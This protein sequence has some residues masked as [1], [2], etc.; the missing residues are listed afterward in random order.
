MT[1][2]NDIFK[3]WRN[4]LN[5]DKKNA[6]EI[7][8]EK[9]V[10]GLKSRKY[11]NPGNLP[12]ETPQVTPEPEDSDPEQEDD[13]SPLMPSLPKGSIV[14]GS[15]RGTGSQPKYKKE[16]IGKDENGKK[17]YKK[18]FARAPA[19]F[20]LFINGEYLGQDSRWILGRNNQGNK[21]QNHWGTNEL[22]KTIKSGI[23][24]VHEYSQQ[25]YDEWWLRYILGTPDSGISDQEE[26]LIKVL[27]QEGVIPSSTAALYI[28]DLGLGPFK[29][30]IYGNTYHGGHKVPNHGSHQTGQD[31]DLGFYM[32]PGKQMVASS[33]EKKHGFKIASEPKKLGKSFASFKDLED[34]R[35][36]L[37]HRDVTA[38]EKQ[39]KPNLKVAAIKETLGTFDPIRTWKLISGLAKPG[40][41]Q[42]ALIDKALITPLG[43]AAEICGEKSDFTSLRSKGILKHYKGHKNH[44]HIRVDAPESIKRG[45]S[46]NRRLQKKFMKTSNTKSFLKRFLRN[47]PTA[48]EKLYPERP[49][50]QHWDD[51]VN[52]LVN[53][54]D[55]KAADKKSIASKKQR[56]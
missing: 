38:A 39:K 48:P 51:I 33:D 35:D 11:P 7:N 15:L 26:E 20:G 5:K 27:K 54:L 19:P 9:E 46:L 12:P 23:D 3:S 1:T 49:G 29:T 47:N 18:V 53:G 43:I 40:Y 30:D 28:E 17:I 25:Q 41:L 6:L 36:N 4:F 45:K 55:L 34:V 8:E 37:S 2:T 44:V 42:L 32:M 10:G 56:K 52:N 22:I 13:L 21:K 24:N 31:A 50:L 16:L 14:I